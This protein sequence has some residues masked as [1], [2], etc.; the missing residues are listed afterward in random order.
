MCKQYF[1]D[2][3]VADPTSPVVP[4]FL[5]S[6]NPQCRIPEVQSRVSEFILVFNLITGLLSALTAPKIGKLSDR[7]G[8]TKLMAIASAGGLFN[9]IITVLAAQLPNA[10][11][12]RWLILGA[13]ADGLSGSFTAGSILSQSYT[14]DCTPP[15]RRAVS[16]GYVHSCL[17]TGLALGPLFAGYL[18]KWT[19][20]MLPIFYIIIG[21]HLFF[22]VF[23]GFVVPDSLSKRRQY[24]AREKH[25]KEEDA[26]AE[27]MG[28]WLSTIQ[29]T[30]PFEPLRNLWPTGSG[31]S[32]RLRLNL[33]T[34]AVT[35]MIILGSSMT[36]GPVIILYSGFMFHWGTVESSFFISALAMVRVVALLGIMPIVNYIFRI[37]PARKRREEGI[38]DVD[39]NAG[40]EPLD[41]W[42]IRVA[43]ASE[44]LGCVGYF[45]TRNEN[46]FFVSGM[47]TALGGLG[48]ATI[49]ATVT[50]HVPADRI[51][52]VLGAIGMLHA[53]T[54]VVGPIMFNGI[55]AGTVGTFPQAFLLVLGSF[56]VSIFLASFILKPRGMLIY[57]KPLPPRH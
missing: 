29:T 27:S 43:L 26:R 39:R 48:S 18:V 8:R 55:Y 46:I 49:Q 11:D 56:F 19:G 45:F 54:R 33:V 2:R 4:I 28:T 23:M 14:S 22:I 37:R 38:V 42:V 1:A 35:D 10:F 25:K 9:E 41:V 3:N 47:M 44:I 40:A 50:K 36:A 52:Q 13:I 32:L 17:F 12:Y 21:C 57:T 30:N 31:T 51:G 24:E 6:D 53:L 34:L 20:S 15:S 16:I 5:G 7:Y